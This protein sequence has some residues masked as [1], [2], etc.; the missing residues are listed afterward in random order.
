MGRLAKYGL[1]ATLGLGFVGGCESNR[2]SSENPVIHS[3]ADFLSTYSGRNF[4]TTIDAQLSDL[5]KLFINL[6]EPIKERMRDNVEYREFDFNGL[7]ISKGLERKPDGTII[8]QI[9]ILGKEPLDNVTYSLVEYP[10]LKKVVIHF[11]REDDGITSTVSGI[12]ENYGVVRSNSRNVFYAGSGSYDVY[13]REYQI[14]STTIDRFKGL[15]S[16]L[17]DK[18]G[19]K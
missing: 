3:Q 1:L 13:E 9:G 12:S 17:G 8:Y 15:F 10:Y 19:K 11:S 4:S 18:G 14:P 7:N 6:K 5:E 16:S 2:V